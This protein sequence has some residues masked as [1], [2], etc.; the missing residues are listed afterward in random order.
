MHAYFLRM[1]QSEGNICL[2]FL[3][4]NNNNNNNNNNNH[5]KLIS[6]L[7]IGIQEWL[8]VRVLSF[9]HA[10]FENFLPPNLKRVLSTENLYL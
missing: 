3:C 1:S 7:Q 2:K 10:H 9:E 6:N 4:Y 5:I 8:Q